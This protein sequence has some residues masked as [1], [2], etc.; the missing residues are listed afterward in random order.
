MIF[1]RDTY[2][3]TLNRNNQNIVLEHS[4]DF[5]NWVGWSDRS[6]G[7]PLEQYEVSAETGNAFARIQRRTLRLPMSTANLKSAFFR[8]RID[9]EN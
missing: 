9:P 1:Y 7:F 2:K 3:D 4:A 6:Q 5:I 8:W